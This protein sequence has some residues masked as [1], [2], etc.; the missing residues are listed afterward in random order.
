MTDPDDTDPGGTDPDD[1]V[2]RGVEALQQAA[3]EMI[4]AARVMLDV[5]EGLVR[6]PNAAG[7]VLHAFGMAARAATRMASG[8]DP[9]GSQPG[10][11]D[12]DEDGGV[13]RIPVS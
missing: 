7:S 13:R 5:A 3:E 11:E 8:G 10:R 6:D 4:S 2:A 9:S 12:G 1:Y